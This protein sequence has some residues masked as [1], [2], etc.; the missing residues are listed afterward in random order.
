M[1]S[2]EKNEKLTRVEGKALMGQYI[3]RFWLPFL[4]SSDLPEPDCEPMRVRLLGEDLVAFR[5]TSGRVGLVE[6]YCAHRRAD[7]WFGRNEENGLRCTYH[8][9]KYDITGQCVEAPTEPHGSNFASKVRITAYPVIEK[10]GILWTYMWPRK[11]TPELPD[12]EFMHLPDSH[13]FISWCI[14]QCNWVQAV[15]GGIDTVHSVYLHSTL[16]AHRRL[17]E[18]KAQGVQ[19]RDPQRRFRTRDNP[20]RLFAKDTDYGVLVGGRYQGDGD[21]DYWRFNLFL[22][23][24]YTMPPSQPRQKLLH[25]FVPLDDMTTARWTISWNLDRPFTGREVAEM[26]SGSGV[27]V[28]VIPGTHLPVRNKANNYL[29]DR[30]EQRTLTYTGIRGIGEQDFSVQEGMGPIVDRSRERLGVTDVGIIQMRQRLLREAAAL[31]EGKEPY[32]AHHGRV[33]LI[34]A[35]DA[36]LPAGVADWTTHE[37]TQQALAVQVTAVPVGA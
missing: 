28:A 20:P 15:E 37:R 33:Y 9:W 18:W 14:Q 6:K 27:H 34:H 24:F 8:G 4:L 3:R 25:A 12:F 32:A 21:E 26:R 17:A 7:L 1:L 2:R 29:I 19:T 35:G 16:D 22:L 30:E 10:A 13:V 11:A 5:D 31:Q 23:P 36:L